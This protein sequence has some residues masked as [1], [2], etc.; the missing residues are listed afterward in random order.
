MSAVANSPG[1]EV[2][3]LVNLAIEVRKVSLHRLEWILWL[4][5]KPG[6]TATLSL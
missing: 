2:P 3:M 1:V 4:L 5:H 6:I